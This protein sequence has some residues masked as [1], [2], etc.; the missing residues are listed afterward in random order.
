MRSSHLKNSFTKGDK[1]VAS[2]G[3][4]KPFGID[5]GQLDELT[6]QQC[7]VLGYELG[8][9]E[10]LLQQPDEIQKPVHA[11]NRERIERFCAESGRAFRL[12]WMPGDQSE[13]W[14]ILS[15]AP[16]EGDAAA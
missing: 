11:D 2:F 14:M 13:S 16:I 5:H 9:I 10:T 15:V 3:L 4:F 6:A 1:K 8:E 7:F 12:A